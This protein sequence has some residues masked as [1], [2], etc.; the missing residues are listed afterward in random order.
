MVFNFWSAFKT[1]PSR[2]EVWCCCC[3]CCCWRTGVH[4]DWTAHVSSSKCLT[5]FNA[6]N[7]PWRDLWWTK[8]LPKCLMKCRRYL[9]SDGLTFRIPCSSDLQVDRSVAEAGTRDAR[10][11]LSWNYLNEKFPRCKPFISKGFNENGGQWWRT[12]TLSVF[13]GMW[14]DKQP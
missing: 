13:T 8:L 12:R 7:L 9:Q 11:V 4:V 6:Q 1:A 10:I 14:R 5:K 3:C 2:I